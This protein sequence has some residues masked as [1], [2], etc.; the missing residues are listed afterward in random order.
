MNKDT[1]KKLAETSLVFLD[2]ATGTNLQAAGMPAGICPELWILDH[3][4][5]LQDLQRAYYASGSQIVY[6]PTFGASRLKLASHRVAP[7]ETSEINRRLARLST[8]VRDEFRLANPGQTY[9]V[10][11]DLAPTGHFLFPTGDLSWAELTS[12]YR[13]QV[14]ALLESDV[15]LFVIETMMDMGETRAAVRAVQAE[16]NLPVLVSLTLEENGR[17]LSGNSMLEGIV[18]FASMG[19]S[20]FGLNCSFGPEKLGALLEPILPI[21]PIP[22]LVKPNAGLP[23]LIDGKTVFP[24]DP[25]SFA[26]AMK[27]LAAKGVRLFGGCCGATPAHIQAL[28]RTMTAV[29]L[30]RAEQS[31]SSLPG[32]PA[33]ICAARRTW[34][35][36]SLDN[37]LMAECS[38]PDSLI[39]DVYELID[40]DPPAICLDLDAAVSD[41]RSFDAIAEALQQ[42][43]VMIQT[44][45]IFRSE[46]PILIERLLEVYNGRAGIQTSQQ[47]NLHGALKL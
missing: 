14:R 1:F 45:L 46:N 33:M 47:V 6:A 2:G 25:Q 41:D 31:D 5:I 32:L 36:E 3:A 10:A 19:V 29:S 16:C 43:Q 20:A 12:V 44:P 17:T 27:P 23:C 24:M 34:L 39:D 18:T 7:D 21:S 35:V 22:L 15:D 9:L 38:D 26:E 11:G 28:A 40:D 4:S 30:D 13:E 42:L 37:V 8:A